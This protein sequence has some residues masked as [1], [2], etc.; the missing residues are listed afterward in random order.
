M[1]T[2]PRDPD[3]GRDLGHRR[4]TQHRPHRIRWGHLTVILSGDRRNLWIGGRVHGIASDLFAE[5]GLHVT[6]GTAT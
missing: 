2:H 1:H 4:T 5:H 3:R 6:P